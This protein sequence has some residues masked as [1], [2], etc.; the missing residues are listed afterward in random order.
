MVV[1]NEQYDCFTTFFK[2]KTPNEVTLLTIQSLKDHLCGCAEDIVKTMILYPHTFNMVIY[3]EII[4][5]TILSEVE[6][7][8]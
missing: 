1:K 7:E 8:N 4:T 2:M 5:F 3:N 6:K